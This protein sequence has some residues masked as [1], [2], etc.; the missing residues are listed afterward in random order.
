MPGLTPKGDE[1]ARALEAQYARGDT[2]LDPELWCLGQ[3][4]CTVFR[5]DVAEVM[6]S[7]WTLTR[8]CQLQS[9]G[10]VLGCHVV[11]PGPRGPFLD[12]SP[13]FGGLQRFTDVQS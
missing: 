12:L 3:R 5:A 7:L 8:G 13:P 2:G 6:G 10:E 9:R 4:T 11:P 1:V